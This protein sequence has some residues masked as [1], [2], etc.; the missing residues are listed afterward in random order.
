MNI[1]DHN[2]DCTIYIEEL[3]SDDP[4]LKLNAVTKITSIAEILGT[5]N[6]N[7]N[8]DSISSNFQ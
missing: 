6:A 7:I 4:H 3:K 2:E 1:E 8:Q 5:I